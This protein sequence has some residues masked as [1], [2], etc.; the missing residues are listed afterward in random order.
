M[1]LYLI[2]HAVTAETGR[3]LSSKDPKIPLSAA[4]QQ[5][6]AALA[7]HL[8]SVELQAIYTSPMTRC[9]QTIAP[10]AAARGIP[11]R[12]DKAF[13]EADY[14]TWLGRPLASVFK[15][16]A[17]SNLMATPSRFRFPEGDTLRE[18]QQ[19][20]VAAV[21]RLAETHQGQPVAVGSHADIIRGILAHYLGSPLDLIHRI[22]ISPASVSIVELHKSGQVLV[23]VMNHVA[24]VGSWR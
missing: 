11:I 9:R 21:E 5:M 12:S 24:D 19:R 10:L 2:R 16:K 3:K 23:P 15:L 7:E 6:A 13:V 8:S 4:G 20:A 1:R 17:W 18:V 14:G 22:N